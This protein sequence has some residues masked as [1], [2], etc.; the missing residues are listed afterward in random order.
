M[1]IFD[2]IFGGKKEEIET[3]KEYFEDGKLLREFQVNKK[4]QKNGFLK[5]YHSNGE[6]QVELSYTDGVQNGGTVVSF[7]SNGVK[8]REANLKKGSILDGEFT[9]WNED[10]SLKTKGSYK[11]GV[12]QDKGLEPSPV[13]SIDD[14]NLDPETKKKLEE[15]TLFVKEDGTFDES[16]GSG[17][18][19]TE[20]LDFIKN[21]KGIDIEKIV[22]DLKTFQTMDNNVPPYTDMDGSWY[23]K[24]ETIM[25]CFSEKNLEA[26]LDELLKSN[27]ISKDSGKVNLNVIS[28]TEPLTFYDGNGFTIDIPPVEG[29]RKLIV[30]KKQEIINKDFGKLTKKQINDRQVYAAIRAYDILGVIDGEF[31]PNELGLIAHFSE[32][33]KNKLSGEYNRESDEFK[34]VYAKEEN[35]FECLKT[36]NKSQVLKFFENLFSIAASDGEIKSEELSFLIKFYMEITGTGEEKAG[37]KVVE[38]FKAWK[39]KA[40]NEK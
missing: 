34:Y 23:V 6:L 19:I 25:K 21:I 3:V 14:L 5:Q 2:S 12:I 37:K 13:K 7:H 36:Y 40:I 28:G 20:S 31:A 26:G 38:M 4:G 11:D 17:K 30:I 33:E 27:N 32:E 8:A 39:E 35:V 9:E 1:G 24:F 22:F 29:S 15:S 16:R 10:G 18:D